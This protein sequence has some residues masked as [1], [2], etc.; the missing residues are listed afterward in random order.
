MAEREE[1]LVCVVPVTLRIERAPGETHLQ[2][3]AEGFDP[4]PVTMTRAVILRQEDRAIIIE[5]QAAA[6]E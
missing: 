1:L 6:I 4:I 5:R 3:V 2:L